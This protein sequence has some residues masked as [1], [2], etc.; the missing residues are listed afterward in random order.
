M[1][2]RRSASLLLFLFAACSVALPANE[3]GLR[4]V[5]NRDTYE[6][7][8][9]RHAEQRLVDVTTLAPTIALDVRY[10]T[11]NNILHRQLYPVARVYLRAPA[12]RALAS[13]QADLAAE[14]LGRRSS[15]A[16]VPIA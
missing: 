10:A 6:R 16:T 9:A 4:V 11:A 5:P 13:V 7:L 12:A 1:F 8:A 2:P 14:G 3:Y 15:M